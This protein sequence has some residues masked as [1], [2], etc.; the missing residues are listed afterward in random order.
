[1]T[2]ALKQ[3]LRQ[4]LESNIEH[5]GW[6]LRPVWRSR[7]EGPGGA[8]VGYLPGAR[9]CLGQGLG[10]Q[11]KKDRVPVLKEE[12]VCA[13]VRVCVC[14]CKVCIH[15]LYVCEMHVLCVSVLCL[16]VCRRP[17]VRLTPSKMCGLIWLIC[18]MGS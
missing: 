6:E 14:V 18:E 13:C 7:E 8:A 4:L 11:N 9:P 10:Y 1:M 5:T 3:I 2:P 12:P 17:S 16:C 15:V